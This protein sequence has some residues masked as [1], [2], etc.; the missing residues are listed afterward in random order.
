MRRYLSNLISRPQ[1]ICLIKILKLQKLNVA[2][3]NDLEN[4]HLTG[5]SARVQVTLSHLDYVYIDLFVV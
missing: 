3:A 5:S 1:E 4:W 2:V